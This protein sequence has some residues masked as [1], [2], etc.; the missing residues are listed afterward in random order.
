MLALA[1]AFVLVAGPLVWGVAN[2]VRAN[3]LAADAGTL[4]NLLDTL[5]GK[6]VRVGPLKPA[7]NSL[8]EGSFLIYDG[9]GEGE[10]WVLVLVRAPG[11]SGPANV[12]LLS[13]TGGSISMHAIEVEQDGE[14]WTGLF[15]QSDL[16][17]FNA[18]RVTSPSGALLASGHATRTHH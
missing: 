17:T 18:V 3:N 11:Y 7:P 2:Q 8:M 1:A 16:S 6:D 13:T 15:S 9:T 5:G 12:K 4:R 14:G 10:S